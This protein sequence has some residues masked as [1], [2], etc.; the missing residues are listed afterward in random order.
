MFCSLRLSSKAK[1]LLAFLVKIIYEILDFFNILEVHGELF[2]ILQGFSI[3]YGF[4]KLTYCRN[5]IS[6]NN[7]MMFILNLIDF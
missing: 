5:I 4:S 1:R 2:E 3:G 6:I 7:T